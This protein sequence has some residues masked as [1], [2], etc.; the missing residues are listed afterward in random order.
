MKVWRR[1]RT[2]MQNQEILD[3]PEEDEVEVGVEEEDKAVVE[4]RL[5]D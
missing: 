5:I 1:R 3:C 2:S 4:S